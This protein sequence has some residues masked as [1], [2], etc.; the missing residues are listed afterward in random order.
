MTS[1]ETVRQTNPQIERNQSTGFQNT[2]NLDASIVCNEIDCR[3][4]S[5]SV[6][7]IKRKPTVIIELQ[8]KL[9]VNTKLLKTVEIALQPI[10]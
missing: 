6:S 1:Q 9:N 4:A 10:A 2:L 5:P 7:L 8:V 3:F